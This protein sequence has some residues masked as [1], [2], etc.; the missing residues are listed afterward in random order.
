MKI[1]FHKL[2]LFL[3]QEPSWRR[4]S[5]TAGD[6]FLKISRNLVGGFLRIV[7]FY[8]PF[9][10][11]WSNLTSIFF[12]VESWNHQADILFRIQGL[13]FHDSIGDQLIGPIVG[14]YI[15]IIRVP[16]KGGTLNIG[17]WSPLAHMFFLF[18]S[19]ILYI[20]IYLHIFTKIQH[21]T[22]T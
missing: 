5:C 18:L 17:S 13:N 22:G 15:H 1:I 16:S 11:K 10:G 9:L 19:Y 6:G 8:H 20:Y 7:S 4:A 2:Y 12:R 21:F 3:A 14:V